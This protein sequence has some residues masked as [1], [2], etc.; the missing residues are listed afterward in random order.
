MATYK[1]KIG[2]VGTL[3]RVDMQE[4][5]SAATNMKFKIT[6]PNGTK[7][8]WIPVTLYSTTTLEYTVKTGDFSLVGVYLLLPHFKLGTWEGDG[9]GVEFLVY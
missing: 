9:E 4:D 7:V 6:K 1:P 5:I 8:E 3:I 2:D